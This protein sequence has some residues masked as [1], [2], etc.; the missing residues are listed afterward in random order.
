MPRQN[1]GNGSASASKSEVEATNEIAALNQFI[2]F[3]SDN[4]VMSQNPV[5]PTKVFRKAD[6]KEPIDFSYESFNLAP[7]WEARPNC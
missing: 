6:L 1:N 4:Q 7:I 2:D 5:S 3:K